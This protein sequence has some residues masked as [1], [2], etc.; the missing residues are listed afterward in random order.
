[1]DGTTLEFPSEQKIINS[2]ID[3]MPNRRFLVSWLRDD[4]QVSFYIGEFL[5]Q[6]LAFTQK[7]LNTFVDEQFYQSISEED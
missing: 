6:E 2:L 7:I 3:L 1:M 4:G 5:P